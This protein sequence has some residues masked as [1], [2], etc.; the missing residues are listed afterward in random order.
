MSAGTQ[1]KNLRLYLF[2][3]LLFL[4]GVGYLVFAGLNEGST[5]FLDVAEAKAQD[6]A[7][8]THTRLFGTVKP[9]S[10][11]PPAKGLGVSFDLEDQHRR[12]ETIQVRYTGAVPDAFK[13][14][15]EVIVEGGMQKDGSFAAKVLMTKCP[16]KYQKENRRS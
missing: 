1:K 15:A 14:G 5:Y 9:E 12:S 4:G 10:I 3:A 7:K 16:S 6:P 11:V 13:E 8:L 2:V